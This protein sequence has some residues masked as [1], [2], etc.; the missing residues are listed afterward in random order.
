[1]AKQHTASRWHPTAEG[2]LTERD[3]ST[4]KRADLD[5]SNFGD[6]SKRA[7]PCLN[8]EDLDN[9]ARLIGHADN[10]DAVKKR[11]IAIAKRKGLS[12]PDAWKEG[13]KDGSATQENTA[14]V[15]VP[16]FT[17]KPRIARIKSVFLEDNA[18]SLNGRQYPTS[19]VDRLLQSAQTQLSDPNALPLTCY[20]SHD[21]ADRDS[22]L[23]I[24]GKIT[25]VGR[26]GNK[27][28]ALIDIP[29]TTTG[30]E[31]ATLVAGGYI[32]SQS[33]RAS[34]AE[35]QVSRERTFPQ[36][37]GNNLKLEGI[38][39]TANPGLP[40]VARIADLVLEDNQSEATVPPQPV[41]EVFN[42]HPAT[43][44]LE[45]EQQENQM[46][47][48]EE[49]GLTSVYSGGETT[50]TDG[51][52]TLDDYAKAN[53]RTPTLANSTVA[54]ESAA[55]AMDAHDRIAYVVGM[56]CAPD[57]LEAV[58]RYGQDIVM[59]R[60]QLQEAGAKLSGSTKKHLLKAHDGIA[61]H[62]GMEC[63][64]ASDDG[65]QDGDD[66]DKQSVKVATMVER[67]VGDALRKATA[68]KPT[69]K[70]EQS[71]PVEE[72]AKPVVKETKKMTPEEAAK[73]LSEAGYKIEAPKSADQLA[74]E[75]LEVRL[76]EQQKAIDAKLEEMQKSM[77]QQSTANP[78][79]TSL[80]EG[81]T[82]AVNHVAQANKRRMS[83]IQEN[84]RATAPED[85]IDRSRPLP[86][87]LQGEGAI[88][89]A[90]A[91]YGKVLLGLSD[92][93]YPMN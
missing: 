79:R 45:V 40:Q 54:P 25:A 18:I 63:S 82:P 2:V 89:R 49:D 28:Y 69:V 5:P 58:K 35:M 57:T 22:T 3:F 46:D 53:F 44:V 62:L 91:E 6:P 74:Q 85:I 51:S 80:V 55:D 92:A 50:G 32:R 8:Q 64:S 38:D 60:V 27:A 72:A 66:D 67:L 59:E 90:L 31:V 4:K 73:L 19:S 1:M 42:A 77:A 70:A 75:A 14:P 24:A 23:D 9:A 86:E 16:T 47:K 26:E 39:F 65:M 68:A 88:E 84:M 15:S 52:Q 83:F 10:P 36:V 48:V 76:A 30:R 21:H 56:S 81:A 13:G 71:T 12:L 61:K 37:G 20:L 29:D 33:L 87:W 7:F 93:R 78:Q 11:L 41:T 34:G 17:P 43:M